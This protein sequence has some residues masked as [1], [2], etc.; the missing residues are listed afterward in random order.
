MGDHL[1]ANSQLL[2]YLDGRPIVAYDRSSIQ[3]FRQDRDVDDDNVDLEKGKGKG[4]KI[5]LVD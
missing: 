5:H 3:Y 1:P 4:K 2:G